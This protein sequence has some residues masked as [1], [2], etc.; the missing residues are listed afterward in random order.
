MR[1]EEAAAAAWTALELA[2]SIA[3]IVSVS[4][5]TRAAVAE[6]AIT[7]VNERIESESAREVARRICR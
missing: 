6:S 5:I 1:A 7:I 3:R 2:T 4:A